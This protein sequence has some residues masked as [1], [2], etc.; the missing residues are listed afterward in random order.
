M[1]GKSCLCGVDKGYI[2]YP[3]LKVKMSLRKR[4]FQELPDIETQGL[5]K[6]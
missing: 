6:N 4:M 1:K 2:I 3:A 5:G